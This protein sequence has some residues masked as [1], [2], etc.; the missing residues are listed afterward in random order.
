MKFAVT[1]SF[2]GRGS[3]RQCCPRQLQVWFLVAMLALVMVTAQLAVLMR[4]C[5]P[6]SFTASSGAVQHRRHTQ[7]TNEPLFEA[8]HGDAEHLQGALQRE[9]EHERT[10]GRLVA[11]SPKLMSLPVTPALV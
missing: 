7:A 4:G 10:T 3:V 8:P 9:Q 11:L 1:R 2:I 5:G 6:P